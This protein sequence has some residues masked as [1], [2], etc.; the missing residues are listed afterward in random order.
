MSLSVGHCM[1]ADPSGS[2]EIERERE[3]K[4]RLIL[5]S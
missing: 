2:Y 1:S 5:N 4:S 3:I